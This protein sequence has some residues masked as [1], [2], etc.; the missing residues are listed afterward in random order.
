MR[1]LVRCALLALPLAAAC[2]SSTTSPANSAELRVINASPD[3]GP[4]DVYI[5][6]TLAVDSLPYAFANPYVFVQSGTI[7]VAVRLHNAINV[8]L[9][10]G[11]T[12][13]TGQFYTFIV[14]GTTASLSAVELVDD[15][16][17]APSGSFKLR[18]VHLAPAGPPMDLY[19]TG[20]TDD[21]N[22]ATPIATGVAFKGTTN[23]LT[24][25]I[26][27][28]RLRVTQAGTKTVLIDS[29]TLTFSN[30]QVST[31]FVLGSPTNGGGAPYSGEFLNP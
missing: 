27:S 2:S 23:Y 8:L 22:A 9:E 13:N 5:E 3:A 14:A 20:P 24:P 21:L 31:L 12:Y 1:S 25:A 10:T 7:D 29:G 30:G 6:S 26:G 19:Y 18:M 11:P 16:T 4:L 15:T 28:S 17:A